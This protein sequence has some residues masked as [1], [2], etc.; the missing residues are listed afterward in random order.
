M[1]QV[2][3]LTCTPPQDYEDEIE[4][5]EDCFPQ[6]VRTLLSDGGPVWKDAG[7]EAGWRS[8]YFPI[9]IGTLW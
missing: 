5:L 3:S 8:L 4:E 7:S 6:S 9:Y 1:G 2:E